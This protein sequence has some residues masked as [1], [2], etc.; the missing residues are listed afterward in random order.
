MDKYIGAAW[1]AASRFAF[2][3]MPDDL[4]VFGN[5]HINETYRLRFSIGRMGALYVILQKI[6][7]N[8]FHDPERLMGNIAGVTSW[9]RK[10]I[11]EEGGDP[12]RE[13]L[14]LIPAKDGRSFLVDED[15]EYWRAYRFITDATSYDMAESAED[16]RQ[17][18]IAFGTFQRRLADYP[19]DSLYES[20]PGFHDTAARFEAFKKAV[21][22]DCRQRADGVRD[23]IAFVMEREELAHRCEKAGAPLPLRVTHNDTKLNNVM[24]DDKTHKGICVIDLDTVMPGYVMND[25]GDS[26]RFGASSAAEDERDLS[27]VYCRLDLFKAYTEGFLQA[28]AGRLTPA[29][30]QLLPDGALIMT[31]ECG[32]RFLTDYLQGDTYFRIH[33]PNHNLDRARSQFALLSDMERRLPQMR[34]IVEEAARQALVK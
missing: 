11:V 30:T 2:E 16:F 8:V 25:F 14:S 23:E 32:M 19:A 33:R 12:E 22:A 5:G 4:Q 31:F 9:L 6:N 29:E 24:I 10:K 26:I 1:R 15:G 34:E 3:G 17:S 21:A 27:K 20:I 7:K 28:C 18:A 13:T